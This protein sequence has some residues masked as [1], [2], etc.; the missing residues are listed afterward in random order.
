[1]VH[2]LY[3]TNLILVSLENFI[4]TLVTTPLKCQAVLYSVC[5][6]LLTGH[7]GIHMHMY[8]Q[9]KMGDDLEVHT[10]HTCTCTCTCT[11]INTVS[12]RAKL[13]SL[14]IHTNGISRLMLEICKLYS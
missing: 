8:V 10:Y 5:A 2:A 11:Y 4:L 13:K 12:S 7:G 6:V 3:C 1:M 14:I 9:Y